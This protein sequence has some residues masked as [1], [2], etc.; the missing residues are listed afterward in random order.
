MPHLRAFCRERA[1]RVVRDKCSRVKCSRAL[2][3]PGIFV[4]TMCCQGREPD[5][6]DGRAVGLCRVR[7]LRPGQPARSRDR[8]ADPDGVTVVRM[9]GPALR[10]HR[11]SQDLRSQGL[12]LHRARRQDRAVRNG[13][14]VSL[15]RSSRGPNL[16][17][18]R[19]RVRRFNGR[20]PSSSVRR[21]RR[22]GRSRN[23]SGHKWPRGLSPRWHRVPNRSSSGRL[24]RLSGLKWRL[25]PRWLRRAP[26]RHR[27]GQLLRPDRLR[28]RSSDA[29]RMCQ[30]A[31]QVAGRTM[32]RP[33]F[34]RA[35][36][37]KKNGHNP[38]FDATR[39]L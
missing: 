39:Q 4:R 28:L 31:E 29:R 15:G 13:L 5:R 6:E 9:A 36:E 27:H 25:G 11:F 10:G 32:F 7:C 33:A 34:R 35:L 20:S 18:R 14:P 30:G 16:G 19:P 17:L 23:S 3:G 26:Q 8:R 37:A 1:V 2:S 22:L 21:K 38:C 12:P 24:H